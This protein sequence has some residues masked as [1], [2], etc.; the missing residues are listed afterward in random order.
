ML[1]TIEKFCLKFHDCRHHFRATACDIKKS[2]IYDVTVKTIGHLRFQFMYKD[3]V[4]N[5]CYIS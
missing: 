3:I 1:S 4:T 2:F 5:I